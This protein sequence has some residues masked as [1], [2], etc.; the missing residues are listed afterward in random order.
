MRDYYAFQG[1]EAD[2]RARAALTTPAA[3]RDAL[4]AYAAIGVDELVF[5]PCA[6]DLTQL[7]RLADIVA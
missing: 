2:A 7:D 4:E 1:P 3:V 6:A 5:R